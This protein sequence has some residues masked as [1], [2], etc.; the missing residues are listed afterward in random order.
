MACACVYL[1]LGYGKVFVNYDE[2]IFSI[3]SLL[4]CTMNTIEQDIQ[5]LT[6]LVS[7]CVHLIQK[8][9]DDNVAMRTEI[10]E[11]RT[12]IAEMRQEMRTEIAGMRADIQQ[13]TVRVAAVEHEQKRHNERLSLI[14]DHIARNYNHIQLVEQSQLLIEKRLNRLEE[15]VFDAPS[16]DRPFVRVA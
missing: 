3:I 2:S 14:D 10:A 9:L 1:R 16:P 6:A 5:A 7:H 13:L 12:E 11:M 4:N 8:N 15:R